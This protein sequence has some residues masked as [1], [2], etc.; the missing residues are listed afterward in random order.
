[1][2][3]IVNLAWQN[4]LSWQPE[5]DVRNDELLLVSLKFLITVTSAER[6]KGSTETAGL[7]E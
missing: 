4:V 6:E 2:P 3:E 7:C 1:M 5:H